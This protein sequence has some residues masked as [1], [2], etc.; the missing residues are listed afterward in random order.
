MSKSILALLATLSFLSQS[1][2][3]RGMAE[4]TEAMLT[5][6]NLEELLA[7]DQ[8]RRQTKAEAQL[9]RKRALAEHDLTDSEP[10]LADMFGGEAG[11]YHGVASGDP[12]P[13]AVIV[14]TRY[15]PVLKN[16]TVILEFRMAKV[17]PELAVEDHLDPSKNEALHRAHVN[18]SV[19]SDFIAK[20]DVLG[21]DAGQNYVF[22]FADE[23]GKV[24][25]VGQT[26]TAPGPS[27]EVKSMVYAVFSCAHF[28]NG[29]FHAYDIAS[30]IKDLDFWIHTGDY[31]YEY[32]LFSNYASNSPERKAQI[33][34]VWEQISLQDHRNRMATYHTDEGL[35]NL[36]RRAPLIACWDDH[37]S[38]NNPYGKGTKE[39]TGAE[40]HQ[41]VC[42]ANSTS[43]DS[44]KAAAGCDRDEGDVVTRFNAAARSYFEWMPIRHQSGTMGVVDIGD[45]TQVI[46]WGDMATIVTFD[47]RMSHRSED[48]TIG[49]STWGAFFPFATS[50]KDVT[51][52]SNQSS[53]AYTDM[54]D[55]AAD[56]ASLLE[57]EEY[58]MIGEDIDILRTN[59]QA[60]K[61]AG[62]PWQIWSTATAMGRAVKGDYSTMHEF[63][64]DADVAAEFKNITDTIFQADAS[65]FFRALTAEKLTST[66]WNR[67]DFS[68]FA[69]E[70]RQILATLKEVSNN[71]IILA[72][73]LHDGYGWTLFENGATDGT[74]CAVNLV[75]PGVTSPGWGP[76][77]FPPF[78]GLSD[79]VGGDDEIYSLLEQA[80]ED[81]NPGL[82][83]Y[84]L[85]Y[86]GF[87][88]VKATKETHVAEYF[89]IDPETILTDYPEARTA[90][91]DIVANFKCDTQL[92]TTAG[93][94]GSLDR[95]DQCSAIEFEATRPA[96][97]D[98]PFPV[99]EPG[100][101]IVEL[102]DCGYDECQFDIKA[103]DAPTSGASIASSLI[104]TYHIIV[105]VHGSSRQE[106]GPGV[107]R[108]YGYQ[109][110]I[111]Y[112]P[113]AGEER[114]RERH[115]R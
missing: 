106:T 59:L 51:Q 57:S 103:T 42:V 19:E 39:N 41:E 98:L 13:N 113:Y 75:C 110:T 62:Q 58:T 66:P 26:K 17:D 27:D 21:L 90:S 38:T 70:Q 45:I 9:L 85:Q 79:L 10:I 6:K 63:I 68:G 40:N 8:E 18:V 83:Y 34:P 65:T 71:P 78:S 105:L 104:A 64:E 87:F 32:G 49:G 20:I 88:A 115:S 7:L 67:D 97:W 100:E 23:N 1:P 47:T 3:V 112:H 14:W 109:G 91:G 35:Q 25:Q 33:L 101:N 111:P 16:E 86:K 76:A 43:P 12:L 54:L 11:F 4:L 22:A 28:A 73:D 55:V 36:R 96:V 44:E 89:V 5:A 114:E 69:H 31:V 48:P 99:V 93:M 2:V 53:Q 92:T 74:P 56:V 108:W 61:D 107:Y 24:S 37:E 81:A 52:Y 72:G 30:T 46:G 29:Y 94:P 50:N 77:L 84:N 95:V 102:S 15:T 80:E 60:S 82:K